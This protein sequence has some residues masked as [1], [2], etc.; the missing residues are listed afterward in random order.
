MGRFGKEKSTSQK[1]KDAIR[2][3]GLE[4][5]QYTRAYWDGYVEVTGYVKAIPI[6]IGHK[7]FWPFRRIIIGAEVDFADPNHLILRIPNEGL[8]L[9]TRLVGLLHKFAETITVEHVDEEVKVQSWDS[10]M[11][12]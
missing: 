4:C 10:V 12:W 5:G 6:I 9:P 8:R 11:G 7:G 2:S 1:V 3:T